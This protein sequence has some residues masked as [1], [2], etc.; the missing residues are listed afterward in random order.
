[1]PP[2][3]C[4]FKPADLLIVCCYH[5]PASPLHPCIWSCLTVQ[6]GCSKVGLLPQLSHL[7]MSA[8]WLLTWMPEPELQ[9]STKKQ[10][11]QNPKAQLRAC[12]LLLHQPTFI[13]RDY[14][15]FVH[16]GRCM[17]TPTNTTTPPA[18][19]PPPNR[20]SEATGLNSIIQKRRTVYVLLE[21]TNTLSH[22]YI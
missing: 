5:W 10:T 6:W 13:M 4:S 7:A 22:K 14:S 15:A 1:M 17:Y 20:S 3:R 18:L 19:T 11:K 21:Y 8:A 12:S 9:V 2:C 16:V